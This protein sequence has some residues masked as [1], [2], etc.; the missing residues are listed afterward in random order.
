LVFALR[1]PFLHKGVIARQYL[2]IHAALPLIEIRR[3]RK[4]RGQR[5]Q[6]LD[7]A[8]YSKEGVFGSGLILIIIIIILLSNFDYQSWR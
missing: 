5:S 7:S 3:T 1:L 8:C 6:L 2:Y 4:T